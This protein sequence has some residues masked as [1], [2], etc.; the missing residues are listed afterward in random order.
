M[1]PSVPRC[2]PLPTPSGMRNDLHG[3]DADYLPPRASARFPRPTGAGV[4]YSIRG[5]GSSRLNAAQP[6]PY[7][8][9]QFSWKG[10]E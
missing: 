2:A 5:L 9:P 7:N 8:A 6:K 3:V 1:T 4:F 10:W